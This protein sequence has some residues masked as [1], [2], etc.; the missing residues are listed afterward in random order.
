[1][2]NIKHCFTIFFVLLIILLFGFVGNASAIQVFNIPLFVFCGLIIVFIHYLVFIPSWLFKTEHFFDLTGSISY[3]SV[4][5]LCFTLNPPASFIGWTVGCLIIIWATRLGGFLFYR[6]KKVG[7]D[8]RFS[9]MK[10]KFWPFLV[11]WTVSSLWVYI[12]VSAGLLILVKSVSLDL[13][14]FFVIGLFF[15]LVGFLIEC[16]ADWQ[17]MV[18]KSNINNQAKFISS[19]LW[20]LSRHPNYFGEIL[21]WIGIAVIAFPILEKY[22]YL[23]LLSPIFVFFILTKISGINLLEAKADKKWCNDLEYISYK[24]NTPILFFSFFKK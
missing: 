7:K 19:G 10:T 6:V 24:K 2:V 22:E 23:V 16:L 9:D 5:L 14:M 13:N 21:L 12:T 4:V 1:M 3:V 8:D 17:K 15:W 11:A 20:S 18:F